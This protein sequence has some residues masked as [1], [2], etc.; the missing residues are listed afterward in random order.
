MERR[1][2][3]RPTERLVGQSAIG[4]CVSRKHEGRKIHQHT[5]IVSSKKT[6]ARLLE[7]SAKAIQRHRQAWDVKSISNQH[8]LTIER[9]DGRAAGQDW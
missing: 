8:T 3:G 9:D 7:V 4:R 1:Q 5:D 6:A 2:R